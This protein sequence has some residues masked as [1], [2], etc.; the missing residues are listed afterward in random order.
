MFFKWQGEGLLS[1]SISLVM[2]EITNNLIF[3][4][5]I[6]SFSVHIPCCEKSLC[7]YIYIYI[8]RLYNISSSLLLFLNGKILWFSIRKSIIYSYWGSCECILEICPGNVSLKINT[9]NAF[10]L[11]T[12]YLRDPKDRYLEQMIYFAI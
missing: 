3:Y 2:C 11:A 12:V 9:E 5:L 6:S 1:S 8:S 10:I 7:I 4:G